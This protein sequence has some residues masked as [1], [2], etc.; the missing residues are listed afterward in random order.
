LVIPYEKFFYWVSHRLPDIRRGQDVYL[1]F[2]SYLKLANQ[3]EFSFSIVDCGGTVWSPPI[4]RD[5]VGTTSD[6]MSFKNIDMNEQV[7]IPVGEH[8]GAFGIERRFDMHKGVDLYVDPGTPVYAVEDGIV[9]EVKHFT[10]PEAGCDWWLPTKAVYVAGKSGV[11]VYGEIEPAD[12]LGRVVT[13]CDLIGSVKRVLRTDKGRPTSMLHLALLKHGYLGSG[14]WKK[15]E[16]KPYALMDPT[17]F[18]TPLNR[19][20]HG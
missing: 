8:V 13:E 20:W 6:S 10:G 4:D 9:V 12:G 15:G 7:E 16:D 3:Y 5:F 11:V 19:L 17:P 1:S 18:L 14:E 2:P